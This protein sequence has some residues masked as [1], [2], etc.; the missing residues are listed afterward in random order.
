MTELDEA[1]RAVR[2]GE[3]VDVDAEIVEVAGPDAAT[4]LQGQLSQDIDALQ[5]GR[6][7]VPSLLLEPTG[8]L[9]YLLSVA[10]LAEDRFGLAVDRPF[11]AHVVQRLERFKLRTAASIELIDSGRLVVSWRPEEGEGLLRAATVI[12]AEEAGANAA[13]VRDGS[14]W[15]EAEN[16][17]RIE[18]G[19]PRG[20]AEVRDEA[21]PA[22]LGQEL[23]AAA[24]SFTK[25]CYTGQ[26]LV[27]RVDSRGGHAP[28]R[29]CR[30]RSDAGAAFAVGADLVDG[31]R[32]VGG[33]TSAA[34]VPGGG[35]VGLGHVARAI[36]LPASLRAGDTV[37]EVSLVP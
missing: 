8:K 28:Q 9:G 4:Y 32:V 19:W 37:V 13:A 22:E 33:V 3:P 23:I 6:G 16:V 24:V 29:L 2:A 11:G 35:F 10:R 31:D 15:R 12:D 25:G 1:Y 26:E 14:A 21:L 5:V 18:Q 30:L 20:G 7:S 27:A 34:P 17:V 36:E